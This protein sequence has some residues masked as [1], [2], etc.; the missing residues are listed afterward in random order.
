MSR[1]QCKPRLRLRAKG[2]T[3]QLFER[4]WK[5]FDLPTQAT[6]FS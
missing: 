2:K 3:I 1:F 6:T 4:V 5:I